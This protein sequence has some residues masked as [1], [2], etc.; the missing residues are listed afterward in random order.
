MQMA[1]RVAG[2]CVWVSL[3]M[4][5]ML[6]SGAAGA[7]DTARDHLYVARAIVTGRGETNRPAGFALCLQDVLVKLSG[8]PRLI[9]DPKARE[10]GARAGTFVSDFQ[11]RD[12]LEGKP[13]HDEQGTYDRPHYL[14]TT[15]DAAKIDAA[16]RSLGREPWLAARPRVMVFLG[17]EGQKAKFVLAQDGDQDRSGDMR[18]AF[19]AAS[20]KIAVPIEFARQSQLAAAGLTVETL[21]AA[22]LPSLAVIARA[23]GGDAAL[24]GSM[25]F[26]DEAF[27]WVVTWRFGY[28]DQVH[29]WQVRGVNF[30]EAFRNGLRG[31]AQVVSGHGEPDQIG[32]R[33]SPSRRR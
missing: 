22:A 30:D 19:A 1:G 7:A 18:E 20:D 12:L 25:A 11:Y 23:G 14:T 24:A 26:R 10:L 9:N 29:T 17:V 4:P 33:A 16:L 21:P 2:K 32:N 31:V 3:I 5:L 28:R 15:F 27:G 8:D 13:I 6:A